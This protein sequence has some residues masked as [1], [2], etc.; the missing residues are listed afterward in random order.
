LLEA[1]LAESGKR[2]HFDHLKPFLTA[3]GD[4]PYQEL[5]SRLNMNTSAIKVA[6]HRLRKRYRDLFRRE[7]ADT[8]ASPDE[9]DDEIRY[10]L[11]VL[12][13]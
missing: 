3:S 10:L 6:V 9:V 13:T 12:E 8:V 2:E 1:E 4:M 7:I 11:Q 5:A